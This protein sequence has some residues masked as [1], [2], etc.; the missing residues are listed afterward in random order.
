MRI[1]SRSIE[2]TIL[3]AIKTF[4]AVV[5]T[6]PRQSGKTTVLKKLFAKTHTFISLEDPDIRI[7]AKNDPRIFLKQY[8]P[9]VVIDEIQYVPELLLYIKSRIDHDR[10]P[11]QWL[12]TGSQNFALMH[13]VTE[14]L[15]GRAAILS[16]LPFSLAE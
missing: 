3:R 2:K 15:A 16:L 1:K 10:K 12:I 13:N 6:G 4:P 7:R 9:P 8:P 5:L 11:G 14:S